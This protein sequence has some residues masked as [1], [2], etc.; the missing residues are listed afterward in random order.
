[1]L[2]RIVL[3]RSDRR[4][5]GFT[6]IELLVVIAIIAILVA[7]LLPAVQQARE[8]A[9]RTQCKNQLKQ[10]ALGLHNYADVYQRFPA[11]AG[12]PSVANTR[13]GPFVGLLPFIDESALYNMISS[14]QTF[15]ENSFIAFGA[16]PYD[17]T[18]HPWR[19][20]Y[21]IKGMRCPSDSPKGEVVRG[22]T[23]ASTSYAFCSGDHVTG[24]ATP[25]T[26]GNSAPQREYQKR[27]IFG[28]QSYTPIRNIT[29]GTSNT[30]LISERCFPRGED[31]SIFGHTAEAISQMSQRPAKCL[32]QVS[33]STREFLPTVTLLTYPASVVDLANRPRRTAGTRA[34][35]GAPIYTGFN[36]VL[37]PNSPSCV[38]SDANSAGVFSAQSWHVGGVQ[39]AFADGS[40]RFISE[41]ID[42]GDSGAIEVLTSG[43]SPYGIWGAL[44]SMNGGEVIGTY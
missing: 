10:F 13:L 1:M 8:A 17:E 29:D 11:G 24:T 39:A 43:P 9:R 42:A 38:A 44:G 20:Q 4:R 12:G 16:T 27:G 21:Q 22:V 35:D 36:T 3:S 18:Y 14:P 34:Y 28:W 32:E 2:L 26:G 30:I 41:N 33:K 23:F 37:P 7:L 6:L 5:S 19:A 40:V 31:R 15:G 25:P